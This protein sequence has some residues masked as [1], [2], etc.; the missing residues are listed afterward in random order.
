MRKQILLGLCAIT[1]G[2]LLSCSSDSNNIVEFSHSDARLLEHE[3]D[4]QFYAYEWYC[5]AQKAELYFSSIP[6]FV[7]WNNGIKFRSMKVTYPNNYAKFAVKWNYKE[8]YVFPDTLNMNDFT[9]TERNTFTIDVVTDDEDFF[10][11]GIERGRKIIVHENDL[12]IPVGAYVV[13]DE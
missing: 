2:T 4:E 9:I 5:E 6:D 10:M 7:K 12:G 1:L 8:I 3:N 11:T 13:Q